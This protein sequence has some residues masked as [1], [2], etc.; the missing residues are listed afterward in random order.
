MSPEIR[1]TQKI[2]KVREGSSTFK[3]KIIT[4]IKVPDRSGVHSV[5]GETIKVDM[6]GVNP[7]RR[8]QRLVLEGEVV[9]GRISVP[10]DPITGEGSV[11]DVVRNL[12]IDVTS[13]KARRDA[14][15]R[16]MRPDWLPRSIT[17]IRDW[18]PNNGT[19]NPI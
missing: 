16:R 19:G 12:Q 14:R 13:R 5:G 10:M 4:D 7:T 17:R 1:V 11:E 3:R 18:D 9:G 15:E 2:P 6:N 8:D